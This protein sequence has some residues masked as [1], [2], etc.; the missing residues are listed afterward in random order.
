[1][2]KS[3]HI[4]AFFLFLV[5][6]DMGLQFKFFFYYLEF[7]QNSCELLVWFHYYYHH[8][9]HAWWW[10]W[11]KKQKKKLKGK[12]NH[13]TDVLWCIV[14]KNNITLDSKCIPLSNQIVVV[15]F[16]TEQKQNK[17]KQNL[18]KFLIFLIKTFTLPLILNISILFVFHFSKVYSIETKRCLN[19]VKVFKKQTSYYKNTGKKSWIYSSCHY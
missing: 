5:G 16:V 4:Q 8:S 12:L 2:N 13:Y 11:N 7:F 18:K 10:Q 1:M 14:K 3:I 19:K 9:T 6:C 17:T 15:I